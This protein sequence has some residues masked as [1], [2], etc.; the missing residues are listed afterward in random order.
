MKSGKKA[1]GAGPGNPPV[2]VDETADLVKAGRDIVSGASFDNNVVCIDE[3][4]VLAVAS[5]ADELKAEMK[6]HGAFEL[7]AEQTAAVTRLVIKE[8][9]GPGREG[10]ANKDFVGK[11]AG[12]IARAIG[13]EVPA[14]TRLLL[15]RWGGTT[16]WSGPSS[17]CRCCRWCAWATWTRPSTWRWPASTASGTRR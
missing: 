15:W 7:N 2:V 4:E 11:D 6:K 9:G 3:K 10:A 13:V 14:G 8:A 12:V 1:I 5:I 17:S 16:R